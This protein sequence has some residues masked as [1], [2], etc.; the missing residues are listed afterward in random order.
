M[1]GT[2]EAENVQVERITKQLTELRARK[3][4]HVLSIEISSAF[5]SRVIVSSGK[6]WAQ[7]GTEPDGSVVFH[8]AYPSK[9]S[10]AKVFSA[11][12]IAVPANWRFIDV[13]QD[14]GIAYSVPASVV[15]VGQ[16]AQFVQAVFEKLFHVPVTDKFQFQID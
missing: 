2:D 6:A 10:P 16:I 7:V 9:E 11:N 12:S 4:S 5:V 14:T 3:G 8:V 1:T 15:D 13:D